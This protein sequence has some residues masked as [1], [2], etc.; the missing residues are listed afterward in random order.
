M[1]AQH[2]GR[3]FQIDGTGLAVVAHGARHGFVEFANDLVRHTRG[4][5]GAC[6]RTQNVDMRNILQ[7]SHIGLRA[8]RAA[9]DQEDGNPGK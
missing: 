7:W 8:R 6:H 1:R 2:I 5:G 4:P 9:A 3:H